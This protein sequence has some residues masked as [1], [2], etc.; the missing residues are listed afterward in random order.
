MLQNDPVRSRRAVVVFPDG[1]QQLHGVALVVEV[2]AA[3]DEEVE[4]VVVALLQQVLDDDIRLLL[5][6][7][8]NFRLVIKSSNE[9]KDR[10]MQWSVCLFTNCETNAM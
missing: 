1:S 6:R 8:T 3:R 5:S 4:E 10:M 9:N 2:E 7:H